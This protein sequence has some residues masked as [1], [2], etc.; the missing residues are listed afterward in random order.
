MS[1]K[2]YYTQHNVGKCKYVV[3]SHD[4][5]KIH[6]DGSPFFDV[7]IFSNKLRRDHFIRQLQHQGYKDRDATSSVG[8]AEWVAKSKELVRRSDVLALINEYLDM[9]ARDDV[10]VKTVLR[11]LRHD[12][13][14]D[15]KQPDGT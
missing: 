1:D 14:H 2:V 8:G 6:G 15:L 7:R 5:V 9:Q 12:V 10:H 11:A 4:G 13:V 3:N